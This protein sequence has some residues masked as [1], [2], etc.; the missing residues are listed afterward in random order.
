[1][2]ANEGTPLSVDVVV[3]G[4]GCV[5]QGGY[6]FA[7]D[8]TTPA[9]SSVGGKVAATRDQVEN[10]TSGDRAIWSSDGY[11][12]ISENVDYQLVGVARDS[13]SP[14]VGADDGAC[15]T[16][17][18]LAHYPA[19]SY[20]RELFAAG[21]CER[22]NTTTSSMWASTIVQVG[23]YLPAHCEA[24]NCGAGRQSMQ[25]NLVDYKNQNLLSGRYWTSTEAAGTPTTHAH[26]AM[27]A[28]G[29]SAPA[30]SDKKELA[31]VRC[32]RAL[33]D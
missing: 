30:P 13:V 5:Y 26:T 8:D 10:V 24:N 32:V 9:T 4:Y 3:L 17:T 7:I 1:V 25:A 16:A 12:S 31:H 11:S 23:W 28:P 14:C 27:F 22:L 2:S 15:D 20:R 19:A 29:A 21:R 18:I 33:S 6:V